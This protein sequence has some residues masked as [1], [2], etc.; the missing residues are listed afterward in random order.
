[1]TMSVIIN[2]IVWVLIA[3]FVYLALQKLIAVA[4]AAAWF[5]QVAEVLLWILVAG[6]VLFKV[7]V[8]ALQAVAGISISVH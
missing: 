6:I 5:K 3:G 1:M 4:P 8:P 2:I 7:I